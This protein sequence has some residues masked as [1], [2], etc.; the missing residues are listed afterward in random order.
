MKRLVLFAFLLVFGLSQANAQLSMKITKQYLNFPISM[1]EK[2]G[3]MSFINKRTTDYS[4]N[5]RLASDKADYWTFC[6]VSDWKGKT[7]TITYTGNQDAL[8]KIYQS[9]EIDGNDSI[10]KESYRPLIHFTTRRGWIND[11]NG[12]VY[13]DG[14][15]HLFYQHNP[16]DHNWGNMHWG[17]AVS[18][19]LI[20]W[21]EL[22]DALYPDKLGTIFSGSAVIDYNNTSGFGKK[23]VP[24]MVA[25]YTNDSSEKEVQ[26]IAYSLDKGRTWTKYDGNPVI[27]SKDKWQNRDTRDPK[28]FWHKES[29]KWVMV[30]YERDGNSFYTSTNLKDWTYESHVTGFFECPNFLELT[31]DG[32]KANKK[33]VMFGA[34]G[35]YMIGSF[36]GKTF[37]PESGKYY[38]NTGAMYAAQVY[39]NIP[40][41]DGRQIMF[42]WGRIETPENIPFNNQMTIPVELTLRT[43]KDG[44][45]LFSNPVREME[46]LQK[47][48]EE[49]SNLTADK[50][51]ELL[52]SYQNAPALRIRTTIKLWHSTT[53]GLSLFGQP[54]VEYDM[55]NNRVNGVFYTP[56]ERTSMEL[57]ADIYLD[58]TSAEVFIDGGAY[59]YSMKRQ[60]VNGNKN[61]FRFFGQN[62]AVE[63]LA[64][65]ELKSIWE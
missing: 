52:R 19:D 7:L 38:F 23:G 47:N 15:Y 60:A 41:S 25:I 3:T 32:N 4:F 14:E 63:K 17:H 12:L 11:P 42:G 46:S 30:L 33:W 58:N 64:V 16:F 18:N 48:H 9:D 56:L 39:S 59:S 40:E 31:I 61:G 50:A 35:T 37:T 54:L 51:N 53:S 2:F 28:V 65:D 20:H 10:Y 43:T 34:S 22:K 49:W 26:S 24:P 21:K 29:N 27:D 57:T 13:Y 62:V 5:I 36:D 45:R 55:N 44:V 8:K 6:D 1:Q